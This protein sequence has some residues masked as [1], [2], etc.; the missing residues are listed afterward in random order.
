MRAALVGVVAGLAACGGGAPAATP[1]RPV[2]PAVDS[3][4]AERD[5]GGLVDEIFETLGRGNKDSLF[6]L[7]D[8]RLVTFGPGAS[9][10]HAQRVD[11]LTALAAVVDPKSKRHLALRSAQRE[12]VP[13]PSGRS[14]WVFDA[15]EI[16][17]APY[18]VLAV[19]TNSDDLWLVSAVGIAH[20][21]R[22][23][24]L[25]ANR[26]KDAIV[27][28]GGSAP[29]AKIEVPAQGAV[30]AF[31]RGLLDPDKWGDDLIARSDA[32]VIGP[33]AGDVTRGKKDLKKLWARRVEAKT[34][35]AVSGPVA[36]AT[37]ADGELAWVS[38]P[39]TRVA[40]DEPALPLRA[41]A[42]F[43]RTADASWK[44]IALQESLAFGA[45][46]DGAVWRKT[47]PPAPVEPPPTEVAASDDPP[48]K[49]KATKDK[50]K[51][52]A[53]KKKRKKKQ[54]PVDDEG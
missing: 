40:E 24:Q 33:T 45:P 46:G 22:G 21:P 7:L 9:D 20:T 12:V 38:A 50:A 13:S 36:A 25:V 51:S 8:D 37:T 44:L 49:A 28:P 43:E 3:A 6:T 10:A 41:F 34:R 52:K 30:D 53:K 23:K 1:A 2:G 11:V 27:P 19:L 29:L 35:L 31:Q 47:L 39:V 15:V 4:V 48:A 18:A 32:I 54:R 16:G 26:D 17:G 14:A 42:V 5:A